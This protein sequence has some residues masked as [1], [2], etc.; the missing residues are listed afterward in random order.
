MNGKLNK[1]PIDESDSMRFEEG[2]LRAAAKVMQ[3]HSSQAS[4]LLINLGA[5]HL[6]R[7]WVEG[8]PNFLII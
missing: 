8:F 3:V 1:Q 2:C 5:L 4:N 6:P 7:E